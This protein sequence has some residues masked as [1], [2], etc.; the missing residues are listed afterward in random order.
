MMNIGQPETVK[1]GPPLS[2]MIVT[3]NIHE[4]LQAEQL[5]KEKNLDGLHLVRPQK[6]KFESIDSCNFS[7]Q[8]SIQEQ[9]SLRKKDEDKS[10]ETIN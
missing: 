10:S 6:I 3:F 7:M 1:K 2:K 4:A 9:K 8:M 5:G